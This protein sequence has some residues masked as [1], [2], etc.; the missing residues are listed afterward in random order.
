MKL[1]FPAIAFCALTLLSGTAGRGL[2]APPEWEGF[3]PASASLPQTGKTDD[4]SIPDLSPVTDDA[5]PD[6]SPDELQPRPYASL[7][8]APGK[9]RDAP[10]T[11]RRPPDTARET[12]SSHPSRLEA[13]YAERLPE[14]LEQFGYD[15]FVP[16]EN[17]E[18]T[19]Q[20]LPGGAA[21]D[22]FVLSAGDI[23]D[24]TFRG[25]RNTRDTVSIDSSGQLLI[26]DLSP[27]NAA[28]RTIGDIRAILQTEAEKLPNTE[29]FVALDTVR[30]IDVLVAGHIRRPGRQTLTVFHTA[31]DALEQAGGIDKTGS[32]RRV[33][34]V[35]QG[36]SIPIDLY[37][38]LESGGTGQ[39]LSL[40]DGDRIIVP[41]VGPT[42][43]ITGGVKRPGIYELP[44]VTGADLPLNLDNLIHLGGGLLSPGQIRFMRMAL[45]PDGQEKVQEVSQTSQATFGDGDIL[46]VEPAKEKRTGTVEL[47]GATRRAGL[48]ALDKAPALSALLN[49]SQV[50]GADIYPLIGLIE[51]LDRRQMTRQMIAFPPLQVLDGGF[52]HA[53]LD[54]DIVTLFSRSQVMA[55]LPADPESPAPSTVISSTP[56]LDPV[57]TSWLKE[58][59]AYVRGAVRNPGSWPVADGTTLESLIAAAGGMT[60][61]AN[62]QNIEVTSALPAQGPQQ[63]SGGAQRSIIDL[64]STDA[65]V[66]TIAPGDAVRINQK[67]RAIAENS[68][69][70]TGQVL[71]P[72]R[73]DL[74][75]GDR[76]SDL[77][78]RAGGLTQ[79]AYPQGT[80]FS[81]DSERRAEEQRYR[82]QA[83]SLQTR[84]AAALEDKG[85]KAPDNT[86]ITAVE[87]LIGQL[88]QARGV[89]RI[90][91]ESDPDSLAAN[92]ALDILLE[93]GDRV[94]IPQRPLTVRVAGEILSP[95]NLQFRKEKEPEDYIREAGGFTY[96][97]DR[98][99]AFVVYPDG[100][101]Q[102]LEVSMW[103]HQAVMIPP[104]STIVVPRDP[105]PFDFVET[106][107]D[108][109]QILSN[110]AV[111]GI[112][113]DNIKDE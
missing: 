106:A 12:E 39:D 78:K 26:D 2:A 79:Q 93:A 32:L 60:L 113:V 62:P 4:L 81:R 50:F 40:R 48:H 44:G 51:R 19:R 55:A 80:I 103:Q 13:A 59:M 45:T 27:L 30:Q 91:V 95:S 42:I 23:L 111:T 97:A 56:P 98:D 64:S 65:S 68:A 72:G 57:V 46:S 37:G 17:S 71:H 22:D 21:Q 99:R 74:L 61:E 25:Q 6:V 41:P 84:L 89:G 92:P 24:I 110:L 47:N 28:G 87:G 105:K 3:D 54:G 52:D 58:R 9:K 11:G 83:R 34:L 82:A 15:L 90:T 70:L 20:G 10:V 35:R 77:L 33:K 5:L 66:I 108:V 53:L 100:S 49:D 63:G 104:G 112:F 1:S 69:L 96:N 29:V 43:A 88:E 94:Y 7:P 8:A 75:P 73:Y 18:S 86:R 38:V 16:Q 101:A 102:P 76:L 36:R 31:L 85:D 14:P 107:R 67:Q 109:T